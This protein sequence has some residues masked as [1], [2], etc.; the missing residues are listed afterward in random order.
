MIGKFGFKNNVVDQCIYLKVSG[1]KYIILVLYMDDILLASSD[2]NLMHETKRFHQKNFDMKDLGEAS[3]VLGIEIHRNRSQGVL[4]LSQRT[5]IDKVLK[6]FNMQ[7]CSPSV[8]PVVKGDK[9]SLKQCPKNHLEL[10]QMEH[11][12]YVSAV[13]SL[14]YAHV[15]THPY[16]A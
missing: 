8:A 11:I 4:G 7:N 15:C 9:F 1:S 6:Q 13:G 12:S 5:Y 10:D 16:L 14:M 2:M 3:Y